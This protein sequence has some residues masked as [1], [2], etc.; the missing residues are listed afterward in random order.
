M[1]N[2]DPRAAAVAP[3]T[4]KQKFAELVQALAQKELVNLFGSE[5]GRAAAARVALAFRAAASTAK[6]PEAFYSCTPES[7][8][9]CMATSASTGIMPGGPVPGCWLIPKKVNGVQ[10]LN[11]W[12]NHRGIKTLARRAGQSV[13]AIPYFDGDEVVIERG[14]AWRVEVLEGE[15]PDRDDPNALAGVVYYVSDIE[16][17]A[18]LAARKMTKGQIS[19]RRA[20]SDMVKSD[21]SASGPWR[22]WPIE[23]AEKTAIKFAAGRGDVFFDDVGNMAL[24]REA[25]SAPVIDTTATSMGTEPTPNGKTALG[26]KA[27][28]LPDHGERQTPDFTAENER[29]NQRETVSREDAAEAERKANEEAAAR[30]AAAQAGDDGPPA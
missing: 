19:V 20:K 2:P 25:E 27:K 14:R 28:A 24:S 26:L 22:D 10:T 7:V 17:G 16:T 5:Q 1:A 30:D 6:D 23:M 18:L 8:A 21:G 11:W 12:I 3:R 13:E 15:C 4:N 29:L 9:A